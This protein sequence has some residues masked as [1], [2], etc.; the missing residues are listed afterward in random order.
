M[1]RPKQG[2]RT[3]PEPSRLTAFR[4]VLDR[5]IFG[6]ALL[7][8]L[9]AA[10]LY[11]QQER[12]FD[13]GCFGFSAPGATAAD[14]AVVIQSGASTLLGVSNAIWGFGFY[15]V[16]AALSFALP[17]VRERTLRTLKRVRALLIAFGFLYSAYLVFYQVT[18]IGEYCVL[19]LIS[20]GIVTTL[21]ILQIVDLLRPSSPSAT[22]KSTMPSRPFMREALV[23][24]ALT[25]LVFV[26]VGA[27]FAYF[28]SLDRAAASP[29]RLVLDDTAAQP[30][31]DTETRE[32]DSDTGQVAAEEGAA[33]EAAGASSAQTEVPA[34]V[35]AAECHY[36]P[37]KQPV[38]N[39]RELVSEI[40]PAKGNPDAPVTVLEFFDPNCPHCGT[41]HPIMEEV[42][43]EYGD[44]AHFVYKPF[45]LWQH[46]VAQ[47]AALYAAAQEGKFFDM[48]KLQFANQQ[49]NGLSGDQLRAIAQH[50][51]MDPDVMVQR[52]QSGIYMSVLQMVRRQGEEIGIQSVP[53][54]L[55]NGRFVDSDSKT[56]ECLGQLIEAAAE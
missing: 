20:A 7:G 13:R 46:S 3:R 12:G 40:D 39:Y 45:V 19:C 38:E 8:M 15:L 4:P 18:E 36:D 26:L 16:V 25:L 17:F 54:V 44:Q 37:E 32:A 41:L 22:S 47:S 10:H 29:D 5:V 2:R 42:A 56:V 9:T 51:G 35:A 52:I 28:G 27:D 30:I 50:I 21:F 43:A 34:P 55:I 31:S 11:I 1:A 24:G 23:M 33:D 6:L 48:L 49:R 53:T 14:C